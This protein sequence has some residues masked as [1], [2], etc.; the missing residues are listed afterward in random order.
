MHV[1]D[2]EGVELDAYQLKNVV[3]TMFDQWKEGSYEDT[4]RARQDSFEEFL[5]GFL[6]PRELKLV[7]I[8]DFYTLNKDSLSVFISMG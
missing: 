5:L 2:A 1:P 3:R 4:Q 8:R 6:I 7:K